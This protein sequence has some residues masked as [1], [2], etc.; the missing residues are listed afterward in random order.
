M[1][2]VV[3]VAQK[4]KRGDL[5]QHAQAVEEGIAALGWVA[6]GP[7]PVGF[8]TDAKDS[9]MFYCNKIMAQHKASGPEHVEWAKALQSLLVELAKYVKQ[10]H[11]TGVAWHSGAAGAAPTATTGDL[12]SAVVGGALA[13]YNEWYSHSLDPFLRTCQGLGSDVTVLGNLVRDVF[14]EQRSFLTKAAGM[15]QPSDAEA[16]ALLRPTAAAIQKAVEYDDKRARGLLASHAAAVAEGLQGAAWV[17]VRPTPVP[18]LQEA[19]AATDFYTNKILVS[20]KSGDPLH[21]DFARQWKAA[22]VALAA[23]VKQ[24]H[25]TGVTWGTGSA[26]GATRPTV[27]TAAPSAA[28]GSLAAYDDFVQQHIKPLAALSQEIGGDVAT[29]GTFI[30]GAFT[31]QRQ[32]LAKAAAAPKP[33][34]AAIVQLVSGIAGFVSQAGHY[35]DKAKRGKWANH[36]AAVAE[37]L[38]ALGWVGV[39]PT[40]VPF[41]NDQIESAQVYINRVLVASKTEDPRQGAWAKQFLAALTALA[42]YVKAY[43]TTGVAWNSV[44]GATF[45]PTAVAPAAP[46]APVPAAPPSAPAP[47]PPPPGPPPPPPPPPPG[48]GPPPPPPFGKAIAVSGEGAGALFAEINAKGS[49]NSITAHLKKVTD[50]MKVKNRP[51]GDDYVPPV[52]RRAAPKARAEAPPSAAAMKK[53]APKLE[54]EDDKRW[55]VE[56]QE[57]TRSDPK[58]VTV[59][60][61][62]NYHAVHIYR[63]DNAVVRITGKVNSIALQDCTRTHVRF[64]DCIASVSATA[65][66]K[67]ELSAGGRLPSCFIDKCHDVMLSLGPDALDCDIIT[68]ASTGINVTIPGE[69]PGDDPIE[70]PIAEQFVSRITD[71]K[72]HTQPVEHHA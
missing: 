29:L 30:H 33:P 1:D 53:G 18:F 24:H 35:N 63:C 60:P 41:I 55:V 36:A 47:P 7:T 19:I 51:P 50:D 3:A 40:P 11:T 38:P 31:E 10:F 20:H 62:T 59:G 58:E 66:T 42:Q 71:W 56:W 39:E 48:A 65:C 72:I 16:E 61:T 46:T 70:M 15:P 13:A 32:F 22:L 4:F 52:S 45:A 21:A 23:Y 2:A 27:P 49:T 68:G 54:L 28:S 25:T 26:G 9:M 34:A 64:V 43:H 44:S 69:K 37:G 6:S 17:T 57:G 8:I 5:G 67:T 14:Q 12:S